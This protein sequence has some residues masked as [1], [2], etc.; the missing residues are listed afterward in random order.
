MKVMEVLE[1]EMAD[2]MS[3]KNGTTVNVHVLKVSDY[4]RTDLFARAEQIEDPH[5]P[6]RF[7]SLSHLTSLG[8]SF[9]MYGFDYFSSKL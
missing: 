6:L 1:N 5:T 3:V 7:A 2:A 9:H 4:H 8:A